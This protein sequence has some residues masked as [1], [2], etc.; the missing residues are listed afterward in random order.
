RMLP[1]TKSIEEIEHNVKECLDSVTLLQICR[2]DI[3]SMLTRVFANCSARFMD[4]YQK[5]LDGEKATWVNKKY[6][7]HQVIPESIL[8]S[9]EQAH[10]ASTV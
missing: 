6:R 8:K 7:G 4:V 3:H 9:L 2:R 10:N 1:P 5:G